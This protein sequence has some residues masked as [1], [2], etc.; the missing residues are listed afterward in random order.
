MVKKTYSTLPLSYLFHQSS[1]FRCIPPCEFSAKSQANLK[2]H[3][4][5]KKQCLACW[6]AHYN[7]L[8]TPYRLRHSHQLPSHTPI[9]IETIPENSSPP[10]PYFSSPIRMNPL[11]ESPTWVADL[12]FDMAE[13]DPLPPNDCHYPA[14]VSPPRQILTG[15]H[16][17]PELDIPADWVA[18]PTYD[19]ADHS[20][21]LS[22]TRSAC[23]ESSL[24]EIEI[25]NS[26]PHS[27]QG[28]DGV[29]EEL[30]ETAAQVVRRGQTDFELLREYQRK[31]GSIV[32]PFTTRSEYQLATWLNNTGLSRND[33]ASFFK[34]DTVSLP[35]TW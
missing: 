2:R 28:S 32:F 24:D 29:V 12:A 4:M 18:E 16:E 20:E 8:P 6:G 25:R 17:N 3:Y 26:P 7:S 5:N 34:L 9:P 15:S 13:G 31:Q 35:Y 33:M 11:P 23:F 19:R 1:R 21:A 22:L 10:V 30:H 27:E 14:T